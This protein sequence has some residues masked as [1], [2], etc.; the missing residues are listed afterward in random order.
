MLASKYLY[1]FVALIFWVIFP[2]ILFFGELTNINN[3]C[4]FDGGTFYA[5]IIKNFWQLAQSRS[6]DSYSFS[7]ILPQ[8]LIA[9]FSFVFNIPITNNFIIFSYKFIHFIAI[10]ISWIYVNKFFHE[11]KTDYSK[12]VLLT[13]LIFF[14]YPILK[15]VGFVPVSPDASLYALGIVFSYYYFHDNLSGM[16]FTSLIGIFMVPSFLI[17]F[18]PLFIFKQRPV[19]ISELKTNKVILY[20]LVVSYFIISLC[21]I[22]LTYSYLFHWGWYKDKSF[23]KAMYSGH[24]EG[25]FFL[26][27]PISLIIASL[28]VYFSAMGFCYNYRIKNIFKTIN[29]K[30]LFFWLILF[31]IFYT[32][33][34]AFIDYTLPTRSNY[35]Y[36]FQAAFLGSIKYPGHFILSKIFYFGPV[37]VFLLLYWHK[38]TV[39]IMEKGYG[40]IFFSL[41]VLSFNLITESRFLLHLIPVY[42]FIIF[43][44]ISTISN[45]KIL[46]LL[47][48]SLLLSRFWFHIG[49]LKGDLYGDSM[50]RFLLGN[51]SFNSHKSYIISASSAIIT[52]IILYFIIF[53]AKC[54]T[55]F[56]LYQ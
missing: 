9:S 26:L 52:F 17:F 11:N 43:P 3:G 35:V 16:F 24:T 7:K 5:P 12:K 28:Y 42:F 45:K 23:F 38:L 27:F 4:G 46:L 21:I 44:K 36:I 50:Q 49:Y 1:Y 56:H 51:G 19:V 13:I 30:G 33:S 53:K 31:T 2:T 8:F 15:L 37:F 25:Y 14:N 32:L 54:K 20:F 34:K 48:I 40:L 55:Y 41:I 10:G 29:Y 6:F 18:L 47:V 39:T 22:L